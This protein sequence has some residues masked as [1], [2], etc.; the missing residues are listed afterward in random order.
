MLFFMQDW[1]CGISH[2]LQLIDK[3]HPG[4]RNN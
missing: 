2:N 1:G 4:E 3:K